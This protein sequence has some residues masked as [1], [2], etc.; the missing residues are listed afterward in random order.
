MKRLQAN[1]GTTNG[2][3]R[4]PGDGLL[5]CL[6]PPV[7]HWDIASG[8]TKDYYLTGTFT[9][10]MPADYVPKDFDETRAIWTG[11]LEFP[12]VKIALQKP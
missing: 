5:L 10:S 1:K 6:W 12:R 8:D 3:G 7:Q 2:H 4:R 11:T 9:I